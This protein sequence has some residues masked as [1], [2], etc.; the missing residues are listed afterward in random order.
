MSAD[1]QMSAAEPQTREQVQLAPRRP[2]VVQAAFGRGIDRIVHFTTVTAL[3]GILYSGAVK[4]RQDLAVDELVQHIFEPNA[5]DRHL[6]ERW[7]AYVNLSVTAINLH[8]FNFS[9]RR[10]PEE[11]WVI[12][13][14][15]PEILGDPGVV[16]CTTNNIYPAAQRREGVHGFEQLF[17]ASVDGR[18]GRPTKRT[19]EPPNRTTDP[20]AEVLYP[21]ELPLTHLRAITARTDDAY[22]AAIGALSHFPDEPRVEIDL[23]AFQ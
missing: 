13:T 9:L 4:N 3:L 12:L 19:S 5:V 23:E 8:M 17:G 21:F 6:D 7:H 2:E 14:F 22:E 18:Y 15:G 16:F 10:R 11:R 20:Q 1:K